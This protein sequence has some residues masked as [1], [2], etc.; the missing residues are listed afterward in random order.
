MS[1]SIKRRSPCRVHRLILRARPGTH[2]PSVP[3]GDASTLPRNR[4]NLGS[5]RKGR[6]PRRAQLSHLPLPLAKPWPWLR[7]LPMAQRR[8]PPCRH[9]FIGGSCFLAALPPSGS[10]DFPPNICSSLPC[11][12]G[13][14]RRPAPPQGCPAAPK[15]RPLA[16]FCRPAPWGPRP[17]YAGSSGGRSCRRTNAAASFTTASAFTLG[18]LLSVT[19]PALEGRTERCRVECAGDGYYLFRPEIRACRITGF[20]VFKSMG[21]IIN[22]CERFRSS[23][24]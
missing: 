13:W 4:W 1:A 6:G 20:H 22:D 18:S 11:H 2:L 3:L 14:L 23:V 8:R 15:G 10:C 9:S 12:G 17:P 21:N 7:R 5:L 19:P 16:A 24:P